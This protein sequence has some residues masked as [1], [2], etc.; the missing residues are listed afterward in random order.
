MSTSKPL[1]FAFIVV[2]FLGFLDASYLTAHHYSGVLPPCFITQGCDVVTTS[3]Y[4]T[5]LGIPVALLGTLYYLTVLV[6]GFIYIDKKKDWVIL[7]ALP[8][9]N[10]LGLL[11][12]AWFVYAQVF[13]I[14]ALCM[15]C[16]L[17]AASSTTLFILMIFLRKRI[18]QATKN[19]A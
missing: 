2:A 18:L 5:I 3:A 9:V 17:S 14:H 11:A 7:K 1:F 13:I 8:V 15:Y 16:L 19:P 10:T 12:S 4:S 6:L